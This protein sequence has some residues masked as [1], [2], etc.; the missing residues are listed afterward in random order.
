MAGSSRT[1]WLVLFLLAL[2]VDTSAGADAPP[3]A[4]VN[5]DEDAA[6][7]L[8][9]LSSS[10][11]D[12]RAEAS[13]RLEAMGGR[14]RPVLL[15][16][17]NG[18]N[19]EARRAATSLLMR[20]PFDRPQDPDEIKTLLKNYGR[21]DLAARRAVVAKALVQSPASAP[22]LLLRL[23][24]EDPSNEV[25]WAILGQLRRLIGANRLPAEAIPQDIDRPPNLALAGLAIERQDPDRS[26]ALL[27]RALEVEAKQPT[28]DPEIVLIYFDLANRYVARRRFDDAAKMYRRGYA[29][30]PAV[31]IHRGAE[32]TDHLQL[33]FYLHA[34]YGPVKG[35]EEDLAAF[36][37]QLT[38]PQLQYCVGR[39]YEREGRRLMAQACYLA[40]WSATPHTWKGHS[41]VAALLMRLGMMD[42][43]QQHYE[44]AVALAGN[45]DS[46][47]SIDSRLQLALIAARRGQDFV[48]AEGFRKVLASPL[49][50]Q[51]NIV[52]SAGGKQQSGEEARN[53][54]EAEMHWRYLRA[55]RAKND[56]NSVKAHLKELAR[57]RP[58]RPDIAM[59][60][61]PLLKE[62]GRSEDAAT[63]FGTAYQVVKADLEG[64]SND[65]RRLNDLAWLCAR[66][67]EHLEE[68]VKLAQAA[69]AIDPDNAAYL[70]TAAEAQFRLG[71]VQEAILLEARAIELRP[72]DPVLRE[73]LERFK[74]GH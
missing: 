22:G 57:L 45:E 30:N 55:A 27:E 25:R 34:R 6:G 41:D 68:A 5:I 17:V 71:K 20:L 72:D 9:A 48:A 73:Q 65:A 31:T 44:A 16:A 8:S 10:N 43:A 52:Y 58:A 56:A 2:V 62:M 1:I 15:T 46:R 66:C 64:R 70:D 4:S 32:Q 59:D 21:M 69:L 37:K 49:P 61:V 28:A 67:G 63:M 47:E 11:G 53:Y 7:L 26:M 3:R 36:A 50:A 38:R 12:E 19:A 18:E 35:F 51:A 42:Q 24:R 29:R 40:A 74:A 54:L 60:V 14:G 13:R 23:M 33:L 39:V